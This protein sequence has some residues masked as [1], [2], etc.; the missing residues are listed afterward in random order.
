MAI[1]LE[2]IMA[3]GT[4]DQH[5]ARTVI[6][7]VAERS[8]PKPARIERNVRDGDQGDLEFWQPEAS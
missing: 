5:H 3:G 7:C 6:Q 4:G 2:L 8:A 1:T